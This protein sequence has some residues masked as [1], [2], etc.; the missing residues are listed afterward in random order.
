M[1]RYFVEINDSN[2]VI[3]SKE[4][5]FHI[6]KVMRMKVNDEIE[7]VNDSKL[8]LAKITSFNPSLKVQ[9]IKEIDR[10]T[11][12][13]TY[14][15]LLYCI[16]KGEKLDLVIQKACELG[17]DEIVL[18][19]SS[20]CV[21]KIDKNNVNKKIERFSKIIKEAS[22]Q[23][24]RLKF[25]KLSDV[26]DYKDINKY[27]A[28]LSLIAYEKED[29]KVSS[30]K[31]ILEEKEYKI[32]NVLVGAEGGFSEEEVDYAIKNGYKSI[33]LGRRILRSETACFYLLSILSYYAEI[34]YEK[35]I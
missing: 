20:R 4:D 10:K 11:E 9:I 32:I 16:P 19:N 14:I 26:I 29:P 7:I 1:Q 18:V 33:S 30:L 23:S 28:D 34:N 5:I 22:E 17:V 21:A 25:M 6:S 15:R 3:F 24:K 12:L 2:E 31:K 27:D 35:C 13:D 8:Y